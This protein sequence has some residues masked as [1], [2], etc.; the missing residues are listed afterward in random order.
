MPAAAHFFIPGIDPN[1][2]S[3]HET[4]ASQFSWANRENRDEKVSFFASRLP[5]G[6]HR[7]SYIFRA[8]IPGLYHVM[9]AVGALMY[10][11]EVRGN[12]EELRLRIAD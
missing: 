6:E 11:D 10:Y 2:P 4:I 12:S 8:Q 7:F 3:R 5:A 9:P 1:D